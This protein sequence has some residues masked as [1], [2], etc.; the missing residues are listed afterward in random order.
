MSSPVKQRVSQLIALA[1]IV[2]LA[3]VLRNIQTA[4]LSGDTKRV[5]LWFIVLILVF[6]IA[7]PAAV[8]Y[9]YYRNDARRK[10]DPLKTE[11][12]TLARLS[13]NAPAVTQQPSQSPNLTASPPLKRPNDTQ[14]P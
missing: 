5:K 13:N 2:V 4:G 11:V 8:A 7:I 14:T 9:Y 6:I 12:E 3:Y 10:T 1:A